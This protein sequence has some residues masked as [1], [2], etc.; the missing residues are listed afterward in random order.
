[1]ASRGWHIDAVG[2]PHSPVAADRGGARTDR[3]RSAGGD[4]CY[5]GLCSAPLRTG[6][7]DERPCAVA[8][9]PGLCIGPAQYGN[10]PGLAV[11]RLRRNR[12]PDRSWSCRAFGNGGRFSM[13]GRDRHALWSLAAGFTIWSGA[14][15]LLYALQALGCAY[16]WPHH[17]A[18]LLIVY[19]A[20][21]IPLG[22]LALFPQRA[23]AGPVS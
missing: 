20:A 2:W 11:E 1:S 14:F 10:D 16:G 5:P 12:R 3:S 6:G 13:N 8:L 21:L 4:F 9:R 17:R 23:K 15:V 18:I 19:A 7:V 22:Y